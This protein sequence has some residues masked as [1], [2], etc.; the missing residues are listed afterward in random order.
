MAVLSVQE[1]VSTRLTPSFAAAAA[2]GDEVPN[3]GRTYLEVV[4]GGGSSITVTITTA[5]T[6]AGRAIADD[7][8]T[9][10]AGARAKIGPWPTGLYNAAD[11]N[12]D[13][14]YSAVTS[15][16]VGAFRLP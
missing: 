16:T 4:N 7:A 11:G 3:D 14:A 9:V 5:G 12:V 6:I 10:A 15:V 2:G 13:V 8:V 1:I